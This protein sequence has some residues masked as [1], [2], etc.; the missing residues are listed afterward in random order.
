MKKY[1]YTDGTHNLG[2]FT[3]DELR[4]KKITRDT[5]VWYQELGDWK[6]ASEAPELEDLFRFAPPPP[7]PP[8]TTSTT[9]SQTTMII[10][11]KNWLVE[12]ILVTL[13]C[14][15][16]FGIAGIVNASRVESLFYSGNHFGAMD[17]SA[18]ARK[19]TMAGFWTGLICGILYVMFLIVMALVGG[20]SNAF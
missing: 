9:T 11:P 8:V 10:P 15:L 1:F 17:A 2:P 12:S 20:L 7:P 18:K 13:F 4:E 16:P 5:K 14:C 19:W 6:K 3:I